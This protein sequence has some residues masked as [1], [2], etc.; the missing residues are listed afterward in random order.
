[1]LCKWPGPG[2]GDG[3]LPS[4][5]QTPLPGSQSLMEN[6]Q[7]TFLGYSLTAVQT[8]ALKLTSCEPGLK[9]LQSQ[10]NTSMAAFSWNCY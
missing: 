10:E 6:S 1:M 8:D 3:N 5:L 4:D 2:D 7:C 9:I